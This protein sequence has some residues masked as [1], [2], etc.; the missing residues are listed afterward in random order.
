MENSFF[1]IVARLNKFI[2]PSYTKKGLDLAKA[3]KF[4]LVIF[5]W[6]VYVTKRAL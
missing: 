5:G 4:Q 1:K 6:R 3:S 2:L